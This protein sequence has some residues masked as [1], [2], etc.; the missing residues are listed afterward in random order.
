MAPAGRARRRGI[1]RLESVR[2]ESGQCGSMW[3]ARSFRPLGPPRVGRTTVKRG[4]DRARRRCRPRPRI[5]TC[6]WT[7][8]WRWAR[9]WRFCEAGSPPLIHLP[10]DRQGLPLGAVLSVGQHRRSAFF[11]DL[12]NQVSVL[13]PP[14]TAAQG[15][16]KRPEGDRAYDADWIRQWCADK[17]I[18]SAIPVRRNMRDGLR[19]LPTLGDQRYRDRNTVECCARHLK[20]RRLVVRYEKKASHSEA[21]ASSHAPLDVRPGVPEPIIIRRSLVSQCQ[22]RV[23]PALRRRCRLAPD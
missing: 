15:A 9:T 11:T 2:L 23:E 20:E 12:M 16:P 3:M 8:T 6:R 1:C 22:S 19:R 21:T 17:G 5:R 4:P 10:R 18:K 13:P 14:R 7:R